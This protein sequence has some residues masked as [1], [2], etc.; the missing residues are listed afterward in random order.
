MDG[1]W[2]P[3]TADIPRSAAG[4]EPGKGPFD[5]RILKPRNTS[6]NIAPAAENAAPQPP[7]APR[8]TQR[9]RCAGE[10]LLADEVTAEI[11]LAAWS[12]DPAIVVP[13]PPGSGKTRLTVLLANILAERAGLRVGIA[14]QTRAQT[15][16]IARRLAAVSDRRLVG[17]LWKSN[18]PRPDVG[19]CPIIG[20]KFQ[21]WPASGGAVRVATSAKWLVSEPERLAADLIIVDEAYQATYADLCAL[22]SMTSKQ[23]V[24]VGDPGQIAPVV[25]GDVSRWADSPTGPHLPCPQAL[26]AAHR[27]MVSTVALKYT[28]RLGPVT[29]ALVQSAFYSDLPFTSRRPDEHVSQA[30]TALPELAHRVISASDGPTSQSV[31]DA[32]A[33]RVRE[34]LDTGAVH[35]EAG[36]RPLAE[37]DLAVVVP[38]VA[39]AAAI[40]ATLAEFPN[41]LCGTANALQGL[42][43]AAVVAVHPMVGKRTPEG[44]ALDASRLCVM[45]S[46]HRSHL[47]VLVDAQT[48]A[49]LGNHTTD[50][51]VIAAAVVL[52]QIMRTK[53]L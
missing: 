17:V 7:A 22:G 33:R 31:T 20:N 48:E 41:V 34:L 6:G 53:H 47:T 14:A 4:T 38:H 35:T 12:G 21:I 25:T 24:L 23:V 18:G 42:E 40:R 15:V 50:D 19:D 3:P 16:E 9:I 51:A 2:S 46:R 52:D 43:R 8:A 37:A 11:V 26:A 49:V 39:Q 29:T 44:F 27:D 28:W 10:Q 45:L 5:M 13:S 36:T 30:G 32:V 1:S